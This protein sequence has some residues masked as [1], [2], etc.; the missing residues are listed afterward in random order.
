[1]TI[2]LDTSGADGVK[3]FSITLKDASNNQSGAA[4]VSITKDASGPTM[5]AVGY[6]T[7][8]PTAGS[9]VATVTASEDLNAPSGWTKSGT[10]PYSYSKSY[11]SNATESVVFSDSL[12]NSTTVNVSVTN[13]DTAAPTTLSMPASSVTQNSAAVTFTVSE[14][15][16]GYYVIQ[17]TANPAPSASTVMSGNSVGLTANNAQAVLFTGLSPS[18]AY[19]VYFVAKDALGN[20]Q[21]T[22]GSVAFTTSALPNTA[23]TLTSSPTNQTVG[24][25]VPASTSFVVSD[26]ESG[27][28]AVTVTATSSNQSL[29]K[30][31]NV[32]VSAGSGGNRTITVTPEAGATG[33]V[34]VNYVLSDGSLST[35]GSFTVTF[36]NAAPVISASVS[37]QAYVQN[38][39]IS[40][41]T[42]PSASDSNV[43]DSV[44]L[45]ATGLPAGLSFNATN[46]Q[47]TGTPTDA[48]G[49]YVITYTAT[50]LSGATDVKTFNI[51]LSAPPVNNAPTI[52]GASP[53]ADIFYDS[54]SDLDGSG[55]FYVPPSDRNGQ[56]TVNDADAGA[57]LTV[58]KSVTGP[59]IVTITNVP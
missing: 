29:V 32:V 51:V 35:N 8:A 17:P 42:L 57:Q 33:T 1:M 25:N 13:I 20:A 54:L 47:I 9:V 30:D 49:T 34:T 41:L 4:S 7:S 53:N 6:S 45:T 11:S 21:A 56:F 2:N 19:T 36:T 38:S 10:G 58:T 55:Y 26:T 14:S 28:A 37:D 15:G 27:A 40:T 22:P 24:K 52:S 43:G 18:T 23:P 39:A 5:S 12:G 59:G 31:S 50:D 44:T 3:N 16:T 46:R 48:P